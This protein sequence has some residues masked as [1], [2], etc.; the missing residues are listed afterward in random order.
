MTEPMPIPRGFKLV[1][2]GKILRGDYVWTWHL[3]WS[4]ANN[5]WIGFHAVTFGPTAREVS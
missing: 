2:D 4:P 1:T 3:G 5:R